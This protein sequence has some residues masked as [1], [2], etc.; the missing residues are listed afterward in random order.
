VRGEGS[1][2]RVR[3]GSRSPIGING[4]TIKSVEETDNEE[5]GET[6]GEGM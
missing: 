2:A 5:G 6:A 1:G 3:R 4:Y